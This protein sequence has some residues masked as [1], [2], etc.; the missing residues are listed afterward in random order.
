MFLSDTEREALEPL[1]ARVAAEASRAEEDLDDSSQ[2]QD[3]KRMIA[4]ETIYELDGAVTDLF[5]YLNT[6]GIADRAAFK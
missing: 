1:L 5:E 3:G 4:D 6:S 2:E